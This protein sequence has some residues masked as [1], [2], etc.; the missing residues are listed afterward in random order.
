MFLNRRSG[1]DR[2]HSPNTSEFNRRTLDRR[3]SP[4]NDY[5][6]IMGNGGLDSFEL[7]IIVP[8]I[9]VISAVMLGSYLGTF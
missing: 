6:L 7:L 4:S 5:L 1:T 8:I 9:T 2:R 3:H